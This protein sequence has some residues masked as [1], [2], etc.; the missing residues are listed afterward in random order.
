LSLC[1]GESVIHL[2]LQLTDARVSG[3]LTGVTRVAR[4]GRGC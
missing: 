3:W 4:R 2:A 1:P